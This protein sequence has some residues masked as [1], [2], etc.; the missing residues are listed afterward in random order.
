MALIF[1]LLVSLVVIKSL[2][3]C[4]ITGRQS[5]SVTLHISLQKCFKIS[6]IAL[7]YEFLAHHSISLISLH[8]WTVYYCAYYI[9]E[10]KHHYIIHEKVRIRLLITRNRH[11]LIKNALL[12]WSKTVTSKTI[13][14]RI[15]SAHTATHSTISSAIIIHRVIEMLSPSLIRILLI[16]NII[17]PVELLP[18]RLIFLIKE[19]LSFSSFAHWTVLYREW[20]DWSRCIIAFSKESAIL[21]V[22]S[23]LPYFLR[24]YVAILSFF[25]WYADSSSA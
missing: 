8:L 4:K 17:A 3:R 2:I 22:V 25:G 6:K 24:W 15:Q 5:S 14:S 13:V 9:K 18:L 20:A 19:L 12:S 21:R 23:D 11:R 1:A 16:S 10:I 7:I